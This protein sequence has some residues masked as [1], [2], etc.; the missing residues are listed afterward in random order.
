MDTAQTAS[1]AVSYWP[2]VV[3]AVAGGLFFG[4][5]AFRGTQN[6]RLFLTVGLNALTLA[7]LY[8]VVASGFTLIGGGKTAVDT[9]C[10]LLEAGV[11]PDEIWWIRPRDGWVFNR[12]LTQPIELV[13]SSDMQLQ[14][15][16]VSAAAQAGDATD[17]AHRLEASGAF[18]RFDEAVEPT[19]FRG[20]TMSELE[21]EQVEEGA[22]LEA[23][24]REALAARADAAADVRAG[25]EKA[26][27][28]LIGP[29]MQASGGRANPGVVR[30]T[31]LRLIREDG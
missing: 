30:A 25:V 7:G 17:F 24:C 2:L 23:W 3:L 28:A 9:C 14:A 29:V 4:W 21:L 15:D 12:A 27:G 18:L 6:P 5:I 1:A 19:M 11:A 20:A 26:L 16:W 31:L 13:G 10:W 22:E 8:F